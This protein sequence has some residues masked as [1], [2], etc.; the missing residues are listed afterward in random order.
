MPVPLCCLQKLLSIQSCNHFL[1]V[2]NTPSASLP[3]PPLA[4]RVKG[5]EQ[6]LKSNSARGRLAWKNPISAEASGHPP[7]QTTASRLARQSL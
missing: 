1:S 3:F 6:E 5:T 7:S 4:D 2:K